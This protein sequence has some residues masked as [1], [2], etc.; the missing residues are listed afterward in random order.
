MFVN[1]L[2]KRH[3]LT[4]KEGKY[5]NERLAIVAMKG[6]EVFGKVTVNIPDEALEEGEFFV[7]AYSEGEWTKQLITQGILIDTGKGNQAVPICRK[8]SLYEATPLNGA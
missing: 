6:D 5:P 7:K 3:E 1:Y 8:G 2:G 4:L